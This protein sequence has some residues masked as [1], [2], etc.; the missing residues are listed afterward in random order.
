MS[1][2]KH[3][4]HDEFENKR[5]LALG[6]DGGKPIKIYPDGSIEAT[7]F[8]DGSDDN[9]ETIETPNKNVY[10]QK[11]LNDDIKVVYLPKNW[12][13]FYKVFHRAVYLLKGVFAN[14]IGAVKRYDVLKLG[15]FKHAHRTLRR[16]IKKL[17]KQNK[18]FVFSEVKPYGVFT[19]PFIQSTTL[20]PYNTDVR[21]RANNVALIN[22]LLVIKTGSHGV[23]GPIDEHI[24]YVS[25]HEL[26]SGAGVLHTS[27]GLASADGSYPPKGQNV[28]VGMYSGII[29]RISSEGFHINDKEFLSSNTKYTYFGERNLLPK[30]Y[31]GKKNPH[32]Q[33][34]LFYA[35]HPEHQLKVTND[36]WDGIVPSGGYLKIQSWSTNDQ[37]IGFDGSLDVVPVD[38]SL[39]S[40]IDIKYESA[41]WALGKSYEDAKM[42]AEKKA[43]NR[44][45]KTINK[46]LINL[47][48][49]AKP[50]K[51]L[52]FEDMLDKVA[53]G[54]YGNGGHEREDSDVQLALNN[55]TN[56]EFLLPYSKS[57]SFDSLNE[58]VIISVGDGSNKLDDEVESSSTQS[59]STGGTTS[60]SGGS[61]SG[62]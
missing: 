41:D 53:G 2:Y 30:F 10:F 60:S 47:G 36:T 46:S 3:A 4:S 14:F 21:I 27:T 29:Y 35:T 20:G 26:I 5:H 51:L 61:S 37:F 44:F 32:V 33:D 1:K 57:I 31:D 6:A 25:P 7:A 54:F 18:R 43:D 56:K 16:E 58:K 23:T 24:V 38:E 52:N 34:S 42:A 59:T 50:S 9:L 11:N 15:R 45:F 62:Y 22:D 28:D 39:A 55:P 8:L 40:S 49:K 19:K 12:N 17:F 13:I 48:I